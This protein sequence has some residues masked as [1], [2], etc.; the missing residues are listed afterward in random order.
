M[1]RGGAGGKGGPSGRD[2]FGR[3]G[4][5]GGRSPAKV[6]TSHAGGAGSDDVVKRM[7]RELNKKKKK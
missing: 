6:E 4:D 7:S 1:A 5:V 2:G 3:S